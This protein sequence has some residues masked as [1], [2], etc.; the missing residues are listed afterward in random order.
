MPVSSC[1]L[2]SEGWKVAQLASK[3][4]WCFKEKSFPSDPW[5]PCHPHLPPL[6][7]LCFRAVSQ[8][9]GPG[10]STPLTSQRLSPYSLPI[11]PSWGLCFL[12]PPRPMS[13]APIS[14]LFHWFYYSLSDK[15]IASINWT[16][17]RCFFCTISSHSQNN[18]IRCHYYHFSNQRTKVWKG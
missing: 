2:P 4:A 15:T 5:P 13:P 14:I 6:H 7:S 1:P 8:L 18:T 16:L 11:Q 9:F 17:N 3:S 10:K 12:C